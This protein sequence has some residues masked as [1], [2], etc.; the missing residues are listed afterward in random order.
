VCVHTSVQLDSASIF[1][2]STTLQRHVREWLVAHAT[3]HTS[4]IEQHCGRV[5]VCGRCRFALETELDVPF[6]LLRASDQHTL[7]TTLYG[8][9]L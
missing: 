5:C 3:T 1:V 9:P 8:V 6:S 4:T 7:T 2:L